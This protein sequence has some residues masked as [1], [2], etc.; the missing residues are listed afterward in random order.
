LLVWRSKSR[1]SEVE[2]SSLHFAALIKR[3][4]LQVV[5]AHRPLCLSASNIIAS[6]I[7][8]IDAAHALQTLR[9]RPLFVFLPRSRKPNANKRA[10][11]AL[12]MCSYLDCLHMLQRAT[13]RSHSISSTGS[14]SLHSLSTCNSIS[15]QSITAPSPCAVS[16]QLVLAAPATAWST[17]TTTLAES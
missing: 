14:R 17:R 11:R 7:C 13:T 10:H 5:G 12:H 1:D 3:G 6:N 9:F 15:R 16:H 4:G 2:K 8:Q